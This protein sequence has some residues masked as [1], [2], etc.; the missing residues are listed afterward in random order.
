MELLFSPFG[1]IGRGGFWL[2]VLVYTVWALAASLI[3]QHFMGPSFQILNADGTP[4][5]PGQAP[6]AGVQFAWNWSSFAVSELASLPALWTYICVSTKRLHDRG[7]SGWWTL[8]FFVLSFV[9]VGAIW[10]LISCGILE[11]QKGANKYGP[12]PRE[13]VSV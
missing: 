4:L 1:R 10:W 6:G 11:G 12:D 9:I 2:G 7:H 8:L 3:V 13:P 5:Q